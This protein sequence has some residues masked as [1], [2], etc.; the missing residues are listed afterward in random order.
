[1]LPFSVSFVSC[2]YHIL[3]KWIIYGS[4][5]FKFFFLYFFIFILSHEQYFFM[6]WDHSDIQALHLSKISVRDKNEK[7]LYVTAFEIL[8]F[9]I[10]LCISK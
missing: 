5:F 2:G 7:Q 9:H 6:Y 1:M 4:Q 8:Y 3:K 10:Y